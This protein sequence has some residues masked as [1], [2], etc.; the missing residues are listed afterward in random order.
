M[1]TPSKNQEDP[2]PFWDKVARQEAGTSKEGICQSVWAEHSQMARHS[3]T[4]CRGYRPLSKD[5]HMLPGII[6]SPPADWGW[7][8]TV[9]GLVS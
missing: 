8:Q 4:T 7:L 3:V 5:G 1:G 9:A 6:L 2:R